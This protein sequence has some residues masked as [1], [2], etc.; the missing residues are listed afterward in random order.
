MKSF[1]KLTKNAL[2]LAT[3]GAIAFALPQTAQSESIAYSSLQ[4]T[5]FEIAIAGGSTITGSFD[6]DDGADL[7]LTGENVN[8][9]DIGAGLDVGNRGDAFTTPILSG[10]LDYIGNSPADAN[11]TGFVCI[12]DCGTT[13]DNVF[14]QIM[15]PA[16]TF[17][18][19]D[20]LVLGASI[21]VYVDNVLIP[22]A[23]ATSLTQAASQLQST[24]NGT[25]ESS[26]GVSTQFSF[27]LSEDTVLD[28][29][30]NAVVDMYIKVGS[31]GGFADSDA[32]FFVQVIDTDTDE[33]VFF[34]APDG[35]LIDQAAYDGLLLIFTAEQLQGIGIYGPEISDDHTLTNHLNLNGEGEVTYSETGF[36]NIETTLLA[37]GNYSFTITQKTGVNTRLEVP[38]PSTLA[39][40]GFGLIG[41][42][43]MY[44]RNRRKV[45]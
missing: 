44:R 40:I 17:S 35:T 22:S 36:Y 26:T 38:E 3:V 23:P 13:T 12:G 34:W 2:A 32:T 41:F 9:S 29:S 15:D 45:A 33:V 43:A 39:I 1:T 42:G 21:D 18:T 14:A 11:A 5:N 16:G 6:P 20:A 8:T 25:A 27:S 10:G 4:I 7:L 19:A 28:L 24:N 37:A 31:E 30:F